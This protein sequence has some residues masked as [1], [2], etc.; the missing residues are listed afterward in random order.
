MRTVVEHVASTMA[1]AHQPRVEG[2]P[3][4][5]RVAAIA[6]IIDEQGG[7][8]DWQA[9]DDGFVIR[10]RNCPY[11]AVSRCTDQVCEIDRRVIAELA[12]AAVHVPQRLRDGA[13]SCAFVIPAPAAHPAPRPGVKPES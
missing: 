11:I 2:K 5:D 6:A 10:E 12:G 7:V 4:A 13:E 3:L 9:T 1:A 8:A